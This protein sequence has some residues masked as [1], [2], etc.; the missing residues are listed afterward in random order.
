MEYLIKCDFLKIHLLIAYVKKN[1]QKKVLNPV[2]ALARDKLCAIQFHQQ[3]C[4]ESY[5]SPV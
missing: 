4:H 1:C 5:H 2:Q 3:K